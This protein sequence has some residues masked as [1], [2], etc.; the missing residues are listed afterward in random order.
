MQFRLPRSR[1]LT[2][3]IP[4]GN[5]GFMAEGQLGPVDFQTVWA[6]QRGD[7]TT[8]EFRLGGGGTQ[9]VVQDDEIVLDDA[10]Y[11]KGQFFF[12]VHPDSLASAPHVDA[13]ALL[14]TDA[15]AS[16]RP[17]Q[18]GAIQLYRDERIPASS[19]QQQ[20]D[21]FLADAVSEDGTLKHSGQFRRLDPGQ[22][23]VIHSSGLWIMLRSPLR[24]D[25]AL[26]V[27]YVTESGDTVGQLNAEQSPTA[28][29]RSCA[30]CAARSPA[31]SRA[32]R[33]GRSRCTRSTA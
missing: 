28:S 27:A 6:Q 32:S 9:G 11:V 22:D 7:L 3:G 2:Q 18:G 30:C 16:L 14:P 4:A 29:H 5:F 12:L 33:R 1:Y 24:P 25:E 10:D 13:L 23:Y 31:T 15:P 8:R 21:L 17:E 19:G 20:V 26:A